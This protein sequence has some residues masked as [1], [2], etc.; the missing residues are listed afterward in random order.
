MLN[1]WINL[2]R[3]DILTIFSLQTHE[4]SVSPH[5]FRLSLIFLSNVLRFSVNQSFELTSQRFG[6]HL[7]Q[8][9]ATCRFGVKM[10]IDVPPRIALQPSRR[11]SCH[12]Y[13]LPITISLISLSSV[14][15]P[16]LSPPLIPP[17]SPP[18]LENISKIGQ[19]QA[20]QWIP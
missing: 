7:C 17:V 11:C 12:C 19:S 15:I 8:R 13:N 16:L 6:F 9:R 4:Y 3:T 10:H 18:H 5:L 14:F 1:L 2:Q 20:S